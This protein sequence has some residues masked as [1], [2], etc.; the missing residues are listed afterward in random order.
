MAFWNKKLSARRYRLR[1]SISAERIVDLNRFTENGI[2][3]SAVIL[4]IFMAVC[5]FLLSLDAGFNHFEFQSSSRVLA[6]SGLM[7]LISATMAFYVY[8]YEKRVIRNN[9][10]GFALA[11]FFIL[12]LAAVKISMLFVHHEN[13][14]GMATAIIVATS[15]VLTIAYDQ[16]FAVGMSLFFAILVWLAVGLF[17]RTDIFLVMT[18]G[19]FTACFALRDIRT[20]MKL[21]EVSI[22]TAAIV[23]IT[24]GLIGILMN[25]GAIDIFKTAG[26][27]GF[28]VVVIGFIIQGILPL[29]ER[30]FKVATSM[31]LL[32][33]SDASQPLLRRLAMEAPGTYSHSLLIG[34]L[35][36]AAAESIGA[37]GLLC[38]VGAYYHDIG[39]I[40]KP[41]YFVENQMGAVSRH[42][43][44]SP[45]MS[46]LIIIGHVKDGMEMAREY[47]LPSV[48]RQ[49]IEG[50][51]G[52]TL[53][54]YFYNEAKK[55]QQEERAVLPSESDFRY[56]GPKPRSKEAAIVMLADSIEGAVR[57]LPEITPTRIEAVVHNMAMKRLQDGQF[58]ECDLTLR[59]LSRIETSLT[60]SL[61]AHYHGRIAYPKAP[62]IPDTYQQ[63]S[64]EK[65]S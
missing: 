25:A 58:D 15:I 17:D 47:K 24:S 32:D 33:Y 4:A 46:Q 23:F 7:I 30:T 13:I 9:L 34:S 61:C 20:R 51:H 57:S 52:T 37:N 39:K 3:G 64:V 10:R 5:G 18:A 8:Q 48:L 42:K 26:R 63:H 19:A 60:K 29:V 38:R 6:L 54:E 36:E 11:G 31:T 12:L 1:Q 28:A 45:A 14:P 50:H 49:F 27:S 53:I 56:P 35:S 2:P 59:E 55:R 40:N 22:L 21:I 43:E 62:D 41:S 65:I 44:L 16:R